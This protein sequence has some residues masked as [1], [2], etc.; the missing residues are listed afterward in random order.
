MEAGASLGWVS[1]RV[2]HDA[3]KVSC[4]VF[5][6]VNLRGP[7]RSLFSCTHMITNLG[8]GLSADI[9]EQGSRRHRSA[10]VT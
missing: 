6:R 8:S 4:K 7:F 10:G 1:M 2:L 9:F 3:L 5:L